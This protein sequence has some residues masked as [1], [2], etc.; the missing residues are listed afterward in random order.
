MALFDEQK[1][2]RT[3]VSVLSGYYS[4]TKITSF[5]FIQRKLVDSIRPNLFTLI[6]L[7]AIALFVSSIS[8][9]NNGTS[10]FAQSFHVSVAKM[11]IMPLYI[12]YTY[13]FN[14]I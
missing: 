12:I 11:I 1:T 4:S 10:D 3:T 5:I 6:S 9:N 7:L 8:L 2:T 14:G 13:I